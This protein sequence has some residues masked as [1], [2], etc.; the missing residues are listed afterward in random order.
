MKKQP[1][2][3]VRADDP[4]LTLKEFAEL[5]GLSLPTLRRLIDA[6][7]GP[8]IIKLSPRRFGIRASR[9][10]AWLESREVPSGR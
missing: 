6:G 7:D 1:T 3:R 8:V 5:T 10:D 4:V 9:G 2:D